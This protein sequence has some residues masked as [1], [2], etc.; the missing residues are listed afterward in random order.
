M[1]SQTR[2]LCTLATILAVAVWLSGCGGDTKKSAP[3][4][5]PAS[6]GAQ[7]DAGKH[8]EHTGHT[9]G[10]HKEAGHHE[11]D[12][13]EA[14]HKEGGHAEKHEHAKGHAEGHGHS[15][16]EM[17]A[18]I[19]K[20]ASY[21]DAMHEIDEHREHIE[22]LIEGGKLT[23]VHPPTE[24]ISMIA[25]RLPELAKKSGIPQ[26]H[27]KDINLQSRDLANLFDEIDEAA[28]AGKK[29]ETETAFGKMVKLIDSLRAHVTEKSEKELKE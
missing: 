10:A 27:W 17:K 5:P 3:T 6:G 13:K 23:D 9:E 26:E 28:D 14:A 29:P 2:V 24:V 7:S 4:K 16:E 11:G 8:D 25:E 15:A 21:A 20:L 1:K 22:H 12:H 19:D 18:M